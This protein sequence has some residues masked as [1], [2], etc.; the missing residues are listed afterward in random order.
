MDHGQYST[1]CI[2]HVSVVLFCSVSLSGVC[3]YGVH[4]CTYIVYIKLLYV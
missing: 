2:G 1:E 3:G 4:M